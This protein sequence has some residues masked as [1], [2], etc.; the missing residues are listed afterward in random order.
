MKIQ[1]REFQ[2]KRV[3]ELVEDLWLAT[4]EVD[5]GRHQA[6][7]LSSPTGSGKTVMATAAIEAIMRGDVLNPGNANATFLWI[8]DQPEL[9][10]QTRR[11]MLATTSTLSPEQF[12][13]IG[14]SFN[15]ERLK[16]GQI[17]FLNI[18]QLAVTSLLVREGDGRSFTIW[19]ALSNTVQA[20]PTD[21]YVVIDEAH[22]GMSES[23]KERA[24]ANSIVQKFIKGSPGELPAVP[25]VVGISA[26]P[27]RFVRL[28]QGSGRT[29]RSVEVSSE[30]VRD[31]GLLKE[32]ITLYHPTAKI[33]SDISLLRAAT[34]QW[35]RYR[36][37]WM[38]Y[39]ED[40]GLAPI[41]PILVVQ[42]LDGSATQISRTNLVEAVNAVLVET[43]P[44]PSS[45]FAHAFQ[46]GVEI[47]ERDH[48][49][50]YL[51]PSDID[52]DDDVRVV[53]FKRSLNTGWDCPRAEV[54]MSFRTA[55]DTTS[56]AQLIGRMVRAPLARRV[57]SDDFLNTVAL[58]LPHYDKGG[59]SAVIRKLEEADDGKAPID[60]EDGDDAVELHQDGTLAE[61]F[62]IYRSLPSY[63]IPRTRRITEVKRL[64]K[65]AR[66][67]VNDEVDTM[68]L[69]TATAS[70]LSVLTQAESRL[71]TDADFMASVAGQTNLKVRAV[72]WSF[73]GR[74][75][76]EQLIDIEISPENIEDIFEVAGRKLGE[77]LHRIYW[78]ARCVANLGLR[79]QA[80]L[81]A[82]ALSSRDD[83]MRELE[84][85]SKALV[86][87]WLREHQERIGSLNDA[88]SQRYLEIYRLS[89]EPILLPS[90]MPP[91]SYRSR[92]VEDRWLQHLYVDDAGELP[93]KFNTWESPTLSEDLDR[94]VVGWLRN[95][96]R[97]D[98]AICVPYTMAGEVRGCYPDFV[99]FRTDGAVT[100]ARIV[101]PH[102]L[103]LPDAAAKAAGL[104]RYA[105]KHAY[106]FDKIEL[107]IV[108]D[109][110]TVRLDLTQEEVRE[111]VRRV[112]RP[113]HL[114]DLFDLLAT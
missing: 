21:L 83:V 86:E 34:R 26:T 81:E 27:D 40:V 37:R 89:A 8:T 66:L 98:W 60:Y 102:S 4:A 6:I 42:V 85:G 96:P 9:N 58:Y 87:E 105:D 44:M 12:E 88:D 45:S 112:E 104:A 29:V 25:L 97:K 16:P 55:V 79:T 20:S 62:A 53:F 19:E 101:D 73:K 18:Q 113:E 33:P 69:A 71:S 84:A 3:A 46:E 67:L 47:D 54:M 39:C 7:V 32:A 35:M 114:R 11:K 68:A 1:L 48:R 14:T 94:G 17:Y 36:D 78:K 52:A 72:D 100:R 49:I 23:A 106:A 24:L 64:M 13:V 74:E 15:R 38:R 107:V 50:R 51:A 75:A 82:Y 10:E 63:V 57:G 28:I 109:G 103:H 93:A 108:G 90:L 56:I 31:S 95:P 65:L 77:G 91:E 59:V 61:C 22:R 70:L 99:T 5:R 43:G 111:R 76:A 41:D 2:E 92:I 110:K 80:K 30:E